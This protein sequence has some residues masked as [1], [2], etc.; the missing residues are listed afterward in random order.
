MP[1]WH[2]L[3]RFGVSHSLTYFLGLFD[4]FSFFPRIRKKLRTGELSVSGD[5][6]PVFIYK[7]YQ[8]DENDPWQGL[9]RSTILVKVCDFL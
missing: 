2:R 5:Q 8:F 3:V 9:L 1:C 6:W 7:G 4:A